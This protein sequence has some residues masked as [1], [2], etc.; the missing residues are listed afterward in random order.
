MEGVSA[1]LLHS[2]DNTF[3]S[4]LKTAFLRGGRAMQC[5]ACGEDN[6]VANRFCQGCGRP[7]LTTC[8]TCGSK[9]IPGTAF[10]GACGMALESPRDESKQRERAA[11][12]RASR[13]ELKQV[14]VL[15]A[16]LVRST[17]FVARLDPEKAMQFLEPALDTMREAVEHFGGAVLQNLGDGIMALFGAPRAQEGHALLACE[18]ALRIQ[19]AFSRN[20]ALSIRIGLHSGEAVTPTSRSDLVS[21]SGAG[22]YGMTLHLGSRVPAQ[23]DPGG[24]CITEDTYRLVRSFCDAEALGQAT[25]RGVPRPLQLFALKGLKAA[26]ASQQFRSVRL[27]A[28]RGREREMSLLQERLAAVE[29]GAASVIGVV[30]I[31]GSGKSRL[32]YE[33]ADWCR[34]RLIPVHEARAH[35]YGRATPL[36]PMLEFLRSNIFRVAAGDEPRSAMA[37]IVDC[38]A[39]IG[40]EFAADLPVVCEFLGIPHGERT[41]PWRNPRQRNAKILEI[42][43]HLIRS[44]GGTTSVVIIEDLHWLDEASEEF[45]ATLVDAVVGT[46]TML[47]ANFRPGYASPWMGASHYEQIELQELSATDTDALV[48]DLVG[49]EPELHEMRSL[50]SSRSGG[51]PFFAEELVRSLVDRA[52]LTGERGAYRRGA[53]ASAGSLPMTVQAV[54]GARIDML[55]PLEREILQIGAIIGKEIE[56]PILRRVADHP[57]HLV[58][59]AL[60]HLCG[61]GLLYPRSGFD[62]RG[63]GFRHPLIQEVAYSTQLKARRGV[64]HGAIARALEEVSLGQNDETAALISYHLEEAGELHKAALYAAR[65]ARWVGRASPAQATRHWHKVRQI[66]AGEPRS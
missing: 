49:P 18:A 19:E 17:E 30:G 2:F 41:Q 7:L 53:T 55:P 57:P 40:P 50:I 13:S 47:V 1:I 48:D 43:R 39:E 23:V 12:V 44:R 35:P 60:D 9:S 58:D 63:Y 29:S 34:E 36:K 11:L 10:C 8:T 65:A 26:V 20:A 32:C 33:F 21:A 6:P 46:R 66:M 42:V 59:G 62:A 14:T 25:L 22:A 4:F 51:N 61:V 38:L 3:G 56:I 54:I 52:V 27:S 24:I 31:A 45:V 37:K 16:D 15:F 28:F 5:E 64:L